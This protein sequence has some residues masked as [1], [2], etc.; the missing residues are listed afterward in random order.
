MLQRKMKEDEIIKNHIDLG[1]EANKRVYR[2]I[3][4]S[5]AIINKKYDFIND[6]LPVLKMHK[7]LKRIRNLFSHG[8][9]K[10]RPNVDSLSTYMRYY[11]K[12][13]RNLV[14]KTG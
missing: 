14:K 4:K 7:T 8:N 9:G 3:K 11:L 10:N 1:E 6:I 12:A 5:K 2:E 13:M